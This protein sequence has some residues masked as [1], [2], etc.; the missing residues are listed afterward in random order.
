MVQSCQEKYDIYE[1]FILR[2]RIEFDEVPWTVGENDTIFSRHTLESLDEIHDLAYRINFFDQKIRLLFLM[3]RFLFIFFR[4]FF[5][6][7]ITVSS[8]LLHSFICFDKKSI[9]HFMPTVAF[10]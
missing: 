3:F 6:T 9:N 5:V 10:S 7:L 8:F 1:D 4:S 2:N